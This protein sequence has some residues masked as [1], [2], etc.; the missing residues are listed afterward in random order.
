MVHKTKGIVLRTIKFRSEEHTS[1]L[2]SRQYLVCRLLL[3]TKNNTMNQIL[4]GGSTLPFGTGRNASIPVHQIATKTGTTKARFS[5][6]FVG[7]TPR[8]AGSVM[9]SHH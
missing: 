9:T 3:E 1:E 4:G 5:V 2:Q 6:H 8:Y 7:Y